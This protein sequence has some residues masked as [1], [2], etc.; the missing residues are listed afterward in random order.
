MWLKIKNAERDFCKNGPISVILKNCLRPSGIV[1]IVKK[2]LCNEPKIKY[3]AH[4]I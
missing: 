4:L 2:K 1:R 3:N